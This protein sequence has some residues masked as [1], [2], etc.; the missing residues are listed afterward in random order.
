MQDAHYTC[1]TEQYGGSSL[2]E[3]YGA[4]TPESALNL[5]SRI[6]RFYELDATI[7]KS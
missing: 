3:D 6:Q 1:N 7:E 4:I 2:D 5:P